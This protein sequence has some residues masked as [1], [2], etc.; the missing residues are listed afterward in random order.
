LDR[1][2][3]RVLWFGPAPQA[4]GGPGMTNPWLAAGLALFFWWFL[5]GALLW[6]VRRADLGMGINHRRAVLL[7]LPLLM[8]GFL[9][10]YLS[11]DDATPQGVYLAFL[12]ALAIWAWI[13]LAFLSGVI[14]GPNKSPAPP[15]A[16]GWQRFKM[17]AATLL[18]HEA[19]LICTLLAI[20]LIIWGQ[21]NQLALWT[22]GVLFSARVSAK[23]NLFLGVPRIHTEFLPT[24]LA[25]LASHF[26]RASMNWLFPLSIAALTA[27]TGLWFA[28]A[29]SAALPADLIGYSLLATLTLLALMEHWF[30]VL[31]IPD[32]KLWR[33]MLPTSPAKSDTT[34]QVRK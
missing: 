12:S 1:S 2:D 21:V 25:H 10:L 30:M 29:L 27:A 4:I 31:P 9:F 23:L 13:E 3:G 14:S 16:T 8:C 20:A 5:T 17:A 28:S 6:L 22:F 26:R 24:P 11:R 19:L 34:F 33:W 15:F 32:Q 7:S 18:W